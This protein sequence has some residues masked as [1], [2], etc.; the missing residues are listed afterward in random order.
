MIIAKF[1]IADASLICTAI[2][3][4]RVDG[5]SQRP[6]DPIQLSIG[7]W[8]MEKPYQSGGG[9]WANYDTRAALSHSY[10]NSTGREDP[11][12]EITYKFRFER[13]FY[14]LRS[15]PLIQLRDSH[16]MVEDIRAIF[17]RSKY[18]C[19]QG[20]KNPRWA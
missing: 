4:A 7:D 14:K 5:E 12:S 3:E 11:I 20:G 18:A 1:D 2:R 19:L 17:L 9:F 15:S 16:E 10:Y 8:G 6:A 13:A